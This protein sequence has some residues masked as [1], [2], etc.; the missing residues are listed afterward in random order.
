MMALS[1]NLTNARSDMDTGALLEFASNEFAAR[2]GRA[3]VLG[4]CMGGRLAFSAI[5]AYPDRIGAMVSVYGAR[6]MTDQLG[7]PPPSRQQD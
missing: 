7:S 2:V 3:G 5:G 4:H 6:L 1:H